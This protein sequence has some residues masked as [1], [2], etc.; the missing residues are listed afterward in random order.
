MFRFYA[1]KMQQFMFLYTQNR[2]IA[3]AI[4]ISKNWACKL[5]FWI[6]LVRQLV[7]RTSNAITYIFT[8]KKLNCKIH[9]ISSGLIYRYI[10]LHLSSMFVERNI[11]M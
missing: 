9:V 3:S 6:K 7:F 8:N 11:E 1:H 2:Y 4:S 10:M 5:L